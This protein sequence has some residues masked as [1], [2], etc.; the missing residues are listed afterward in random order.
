MTDPPRPVTREAA[1]MPRMIRLRTWADDG[2][3]T[4]VIVG[5]PSREET[6]VLSPFTGV[7]VACP[8]ACRVDRA[9]SR[10]SGRVLLLAWRPDEDER[11][12]PAPDRRGRC[13]GRRLPALG[14]NRGPAAQARPGAETRHRPPGHRFGH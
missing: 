12:D 10:T 6:S 9:R 13:G 7:I 14:K 8:M 11:S 5:S 4:P 3:D 1:A 2:R